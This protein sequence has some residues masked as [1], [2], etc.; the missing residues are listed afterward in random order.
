MSDIKLTEGR[1]ILQELGVTND[2]VWTYF[3]SQHQF[4]MNQMNVTYKLAIST[5][6]SA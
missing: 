5:I 3:D 2:P 1:R 6:R 4:I